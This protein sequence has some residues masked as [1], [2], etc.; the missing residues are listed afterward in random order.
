V[1]E[2]WAE[3]SKE[4][5]DGTIISIGVVVLKHVTSC[6]RYAQLAGRR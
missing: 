5:Q 1:A 4:R 2:L 6:F 3:L